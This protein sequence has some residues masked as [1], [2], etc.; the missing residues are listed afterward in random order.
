M[1]YDEFNRLPFDLK[2]VDLNWD[3]WRPI[4][5]KTYLVEYKWYDKDKPI[6]LIGHFDEVW[7]GF[8]FNWCW[9]VLQLDRS[10]LQLDLEHKWYDKDR[11][12]FRRI[13]E[14]Q[15]YKLFK[16]EGPED[17]ITDEDIAV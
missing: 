13:W 11:K 5:G 16:L 12:A 6:Y 14:F 15:T 4:K 3:T 7:Y 9:S 2:E 1:D 17:F 8:T 10:V